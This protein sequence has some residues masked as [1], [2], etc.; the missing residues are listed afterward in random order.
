[1]II[2]NKFDIKDTVYLITD[3]DQLPRIVTAI[4][5]FPESI[6]YELSCGTTSSGHYEFEMSLTKDFSK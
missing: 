2:N 1:M 4:N 3:E 6:T 5:V